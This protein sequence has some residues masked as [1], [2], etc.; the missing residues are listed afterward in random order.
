MN[1]GEHEQVHRDL[2]V[3]VLGALEPA[4]RDQVERHLAECE[5]CRDELA[6]LAAMPSLLARATAA[7]ESGPELP[8]LGPVVERILRE[9]RASR[10]RNRVFAAFAVVAALVTAGVVAGPLLTSPSGQRYVANAG[11]VTASVEE[12]DWGMSVLIQVEQLPDHDGFVAVAV[13]KDGHKTQVASWTATDGPSTIE[14]ACYLAPG[15]VARMEIV[16]APGE[17]VV[18]VLRPAKT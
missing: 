17:K 15:D 18:A 4:E 10:R 12:R 16:A 3:Y 5:T 13:A 11:A 1:A 6:S 8:A 7:T 9:R 14:G 2:G